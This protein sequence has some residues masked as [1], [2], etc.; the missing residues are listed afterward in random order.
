[1][2]NL[3]AREYLN[4]LQEIDTNINQ[5]IERLAEM[6]I[7]AVSGG[8]ID[9]SRER[10]QVSMT[11]DKLCNDVSRYVDFNEMI[12]AEIDK[13]IDAKNQIISE[14]RGLHTNNY[15]NVLYKIYVQFKSVKDAAQ[16]MKK[17]YS[18]TIA[19]HSAALKA[20]EEAYPERH[21]L[22]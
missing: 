21:Y 16:E 11:G 18:H 2:K 5:D 15:I 12:N 1:M 14:I 8:G 6:K 20:F 22:T 9:Y 19:L 17:S 13:F 7:N 10:V 4:Q 3:S